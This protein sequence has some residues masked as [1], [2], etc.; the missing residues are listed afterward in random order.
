MTLSDRFSSQSSTP[1]PTPLSRRVFLPDLAALAPT[2]KV[3][4]LT[5]NCFSRIPPHIFR[6]SNLEILDLH[7][8]SRPLQT[9]EHYM[10]STYL[11]KPLH[12]LRIFYP[13]ISPCMFYE[14]RLKFPRIIISQTTVP[15]GSWGPCRPSLT[16]SH[17][18]G[19]S[20]SEAS[21]PGS[22]RRSRPHISTPDRASSRGS[23]G[24][25]A[26]CVM[27]S[28]GTRWTRTLA[29]TTAVWR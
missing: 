12:I 29:V 4:S 22:T 15:C 26:I 8:R 28:M 6:L 17:T 7:G 18:C 27:S 11:C 24:C 13:C 10:I 5:G 3:L 25:Q 21:T 20:T 2:L 23:L 9:K 16:S 19:C 14:T 1:I